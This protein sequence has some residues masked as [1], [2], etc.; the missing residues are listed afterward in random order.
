MTWQL[1]LAEKRRWGAAE[2]CGR[3]LFWKSCAEKNS[4][5]VAVERE[6]Q[7]LSVK[8]KFKSTKQ[9]RRGEEE[10]KNGKSESQPVRQ[11]A[12]LRWVRPFP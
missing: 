7:I 12:G 4:T 3:F 9:L 11:T 6:N 5:K 10:A 1:A 8:N 2:L